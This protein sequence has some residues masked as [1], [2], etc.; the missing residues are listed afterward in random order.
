MNFEEWL[1]GFIKDFGV[2]VTLLGLGIPALISF[3]E[4]KEQAKAIPELR[5]AVV[6]IQK[7]VASLQSKVAPIPQLQMTVVEIQKD[8]AQL[9]PMV[10]DIE[11]SLNELG[12]KIDKL[13][14]NMKEDMDILKRALSV[15]RQ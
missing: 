8:V 11:K 9:Q 4:L 15:P 10:Q 5:A 1:P 2:V 3:G 7:D 14:D 6:Q 12:N 13:S